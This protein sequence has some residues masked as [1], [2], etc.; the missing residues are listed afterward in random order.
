MTISNL[1]ELAVIGVIL[2]AGSIMKLRSRR[3][4]SNIEVSLATIKKGACR[5]RVVQVYEDR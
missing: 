5:G 1:V 2:I 3:I 4:V